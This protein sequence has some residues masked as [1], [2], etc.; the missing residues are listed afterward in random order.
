MLVELSPR[1]KEDR[2]RFREFVQEKITPFAGQWDREGRIPTRIIA[3]LKEQGYLAA[4]A[5]RNEGGIGM[6]PITYGLLTEEIARGCSS[7]RSLLTV[8]DMVMLS[9]LRWGSRSLKEQFAEPLMCGDMIAALALSEPAAGSDVSSVET[10]VRADGFHLVLTGKKSWVTFGQIADLF[11]VVARCATGLTAIAVP[12]GTPGLIRREIS[13]AGTRASLLANLEFDECRVPAAYVVGKP[14][15]AAVQ[16]VPTALDHGRY[17]VAWGCVG[18]AQACLE[19]SLEYANRRKQFGVVIAKHQLIQRKLSDMIVNTR[20]ARL[21][22]YRAGYLRQSNSP[23]AIGETMIAKYFASKAATRAANDAVQVHGANGLTDDYPVIRFL[24]DA[25]VME[26]IEG[27]TQIQQIAIAT[28]P[29][30]EV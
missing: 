9:I 27:S 25:K 22:C 3:E 29:P 19:A 26:V 7:V 24:R 10:E 5:P 28:C 15:F 12:A 17:S 20:A 14:G 13:V 1:Q 8:H 11:L 2:Y 23:D 6:D 18:I 16:A 21:L 4:P 30:K